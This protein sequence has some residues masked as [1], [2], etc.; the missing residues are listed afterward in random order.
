MEIKNIP[1]P[2][3]RGA[4]GSLCYRIPS[5][6]TLNDGSLIAFAD[7]RHNHGLDSPNNLDTAVSLYSNDNWQTGALNHFDDFPDGVDNKKSA[8]F[9]DPAC[10]QSKKTGDIF[11]ITDVFPGSTGPW[12]ALKGA[13][14]IEKNGEKRLALTDS[15]KREN[16]ENFKYYI[17]SFKDGFAEILN[18]SDDSPSEYSVDEE[19]NLYKN[20]APLYM[21]QNGTGK[22][23]N[24]KVFYDGAELTLFKTMYMGVRISRDN[25]KSF[26]PLKIITPDVKNENESFFGV[27]PGRGFIADKNGKERI[28][29]PVYENSRGYEMT[30]VIYSDDGGNTFKRSNPIGK[31]DE[32]GKTSE[33]QIVS[34]PGK[35]R[36]YSRSD[37]NYIAFSE[38]FDG[39]ENWTDFKYDYSLGKVTK[40]CM[41]SFINY[42]SDLV[43]ASLG[44]NVNERGD[45]V[46]IVGRIKD[47]SIEWLKRHELNK[48]FFGYSC[49]TE[50]RDG[51]V[52]VLYEDEWY[53]IK[54]QNIKF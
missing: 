29:F 36:L 17:G 35:L 10:V 25:G 45:G 50:N 12:D 26:G 40:D 15:E 13:G 21:E 18:V 41:A 9:I 19:Y 39:G 5:L 44:S 16:I 52:T 49:L 46:I 1:C 31:E 22:K 24:Q 28:I 27:G 48:G 34:L 20:K 51:S 14:S 3:E 37:K 6:T 11:V 4:L 23:I 54:A 8:S 2:F 32:V 43:L 47:G 7:V 42:G 53:H 30:S 33:G 38:S